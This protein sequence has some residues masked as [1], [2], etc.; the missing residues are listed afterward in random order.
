MN[1]R[2]GKKGIGY[3]EKDYKNLIEEVSGISF[4]S[5]FNSYIWG[6]KDFTKELKKHLK[7]A[8]FELKKINS[9]LATERRGMIV[10]VVKQGVKVVHVENQSASYE[11]GL[12]RADVITA[13]NGYPVK[14]DLDN[15]LHYFEG[16]KVVL[17]VIRNGK[18]KLVTLAPSNS[19]QFWEQFVK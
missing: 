12:S 9:K 16:E 4:T 11:A 6:T 17:Q 2:F 5:F 18:Q 14:Q 19:F 1:D 8:G 13:V 3:S 10:S 7:F 15:W